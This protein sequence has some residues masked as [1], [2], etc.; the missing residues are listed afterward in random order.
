MVKNFKNYFSFSVLTIF[1]QECFGFNRLKLIGESFP[2]HLPDGWVKVGLYFADNSK[3]T[4]IIAT[5]EGEA[6]ITAM[7]N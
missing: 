2:Q 6:Q 7:K 4:N 5:F 1:F 3:M